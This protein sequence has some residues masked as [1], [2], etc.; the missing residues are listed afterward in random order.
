MIV[1]VERSFGSALAMTAENVRLQSVVETSLYG[2]DLPALEAFYSTVLGLTL[3]DKDPDRHLF[4]QVGPANMLLLFK[5]ETTLHHGVF[6]P[7]G[8][9]GPGHAAFGIPAGQLPAWR[10]RL[11]SHHVA[12]EKEF[13]WP[14]GGHSLYFRDPAGNSVE[15]ITPGVWGLPSG[16]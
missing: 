2:D 10:T 7:H 1:T 4:F 16:W 3:C 9:R 11:Q 8:A 5:P 6:P 14:K 13:S 15:L 12:I